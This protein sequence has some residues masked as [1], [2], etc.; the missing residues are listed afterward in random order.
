MNLPAGRQA[1][2]KLVKVFQE[3]IVWQKA[4]Q[5]VLFIS[6]LDSGS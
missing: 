1:G 5:F 2:K 6:I 3:L 4:R